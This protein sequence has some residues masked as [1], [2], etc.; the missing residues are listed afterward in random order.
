MVFPEA[1]P[2]SP[3]PPAELVAETVALALAED[4]GPV[5]DLTSALLSVDVLAKARIEMR[6]SGVL[7]GTA[8]A[9]EAFWQVDPDTKLAWNARDG[10][11]LA[12]GQV[13]A[14]VAGRLASLCTAERVALNFLGH[15]SGVATHTRRFVDLAAG[16]VAILDTRKTTPGLRG[17]EKAAVRAGGGCSHRASLSEWVMLK[18]NHLTA[19][20]IEAS[21]H[22][23]KSRWPQRRVQVECDSVEQARQALASGADALLLDNMTP[24]QVRQVA[25]LADGSYGSGGSRVRQSGS[26][27]FPPPGSEQFPP[28]PSEQFPSEPV[29]L[30][31]SGGITLENLAQYLDLGIDAISSGSLVGGAQALDIGLDIDLSSHSSS[32]DPS[33]IG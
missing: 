5:G 25:E 19:L 32:P 15:L 11:Q 3:Q 21:V 6:S 14:V 26:E 17:L 22:A 12:A 33:S 24:A 29:Y 7:A 16:K 8:C 23:A 2:Q 13:I 31:V 4:I 1:S 18:D 10:D 30:E 9:T 20:E 28:P 27:Q